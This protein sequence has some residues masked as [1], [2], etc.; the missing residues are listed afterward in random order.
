MSH[1]LEKL[2][3]P[4]FFK[5]NSE[6]LLNKISK[7]FGAEIPEDLFLEI[8]QVCKKSFRESKDLADKTHPTYEVTLLK[9]GPVAAVKQ[10]VQDI[11]SR[12]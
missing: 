6:E 1:Q 4:I 10:I 9:Q 2:D 12:F 11:S 5:G 8:E 3:K 7:I